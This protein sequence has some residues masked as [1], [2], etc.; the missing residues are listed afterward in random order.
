MNH[1]L[2]SAQWWIFKN[3]HKHKHL[4]CLYWSQIDTNYYCE[5]DNNIDI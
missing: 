2:M 5:A 4:Y 3:K 1:Y